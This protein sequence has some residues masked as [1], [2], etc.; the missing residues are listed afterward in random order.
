MTDQEFNILQNNLAE[1]S[2]SL[3]LAL[4]HIL[5]QEAEMSVL[6]KALERRRL[7]SAT[8][9]ETARADMIES[10]KVILQGPAVSSPAVTPALVG[11]LAEA[12]CR[13]RFR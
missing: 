7:L 4:R 9:F 3:N 6:R 2:A 8:E 5:N 13:H 10:V 11:N 1:L 12:R